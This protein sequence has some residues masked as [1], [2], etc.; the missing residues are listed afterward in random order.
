MAAILLTTQPVQTYSGREFVSATGTVSIY[1]S[2]GDWLL[3]RAKAGI[4]PVDVSTSVVVC[5]VERWAVFEELHRGNTVRTY[6]ALA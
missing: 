6:F 5:G 3:E 1:P 4:T 2:I